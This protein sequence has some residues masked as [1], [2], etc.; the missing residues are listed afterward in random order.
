MKKIIYSTIC[1]LLLL[2]ITNAETVRVGLEP[3]PPLINEDGT[4]L[5]I[6]LFKKVESKSDFTFKIEIMTYTRALTMLEKKELDLIA[7]TPQGGSE[8]AFYEYGLDIEWS[9]PVR[10]AI[11]TTSSTVLSDS[12]I[13][14]MKMLGIPQ[15]NADFFNAIYGIPKDNFYEG[16]IV[17]LLGMLKKGRING[18]LFERTASIVNI[19]KQ[20]ISGLYYQVLDEEPV[21]ASMSVQKSDSGKKLKAKLDE[22]L[23]SE[24][25][26]NIFTVYEEVEKLPKTGAVELD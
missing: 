7:I 21:G 26:S 19:K 10:N 18:F 23:K 5:L 17:N 6:D 4:G 11:F 15:G 22:L 1:L 16:A 3:F 13:K 9:I 24:D 25:I 14:G 8:P 2:V 12:E 20:K